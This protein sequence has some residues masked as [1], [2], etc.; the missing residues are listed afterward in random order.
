MEFNQRT[1]S[2]IA[3]ALPVWAMCTALAHASV[4]V[5][6]TRVVYPA[7]EREVTV[8]LSNE[9]DTPALVQA[10]IDSG[11]AAV[12]PDDASVPFMLTPPIFRLDPKK[13]QS[14]RVIYTQEP[15]PKDRESLFWLNVL[16]VPPMASRTGD[17][18]SH[19]Q[20]AFRSRIKL[21]FR[22][23][24]LPGD[25]GEAAQKITWQIVPGKNGAYQLEAVNPTPYHVTFSKVSV[26]AG[27]TTWTSN[28]GGMV[29]PLATADFDVGDVRAVPASGLQVDYT[30]I[31]DFGAGVSGVYRPANP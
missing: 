25:P 11:N 20:L 17:D 9:G 12:M 31:N 3:A 26:T 14:L 29:D 27:G 30:F 15:L 23:A 16:E 18:A 8:R 4:V 1:R 13:G 21:F 6:E 22:P 10:W 2:C 28:A 5:G 24:G 7:Q 19:L